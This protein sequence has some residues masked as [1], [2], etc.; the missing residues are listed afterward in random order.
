MWMAD[1]LDGAATKKENQ[2]PMVGGA[3]TEIGENQN[4]SPCMRPMTKASGSTPSNCPSPMMA[5]SATWKDL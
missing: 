3:T 1:E 2:K 4:C 5:P